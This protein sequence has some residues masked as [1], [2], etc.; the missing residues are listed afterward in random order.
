MANSPKLL[1]TLTVGTTAVPLYTVTDNG[2]GNGFNHH[3][4]GLSV[5]VQS[6]PLNAGKIFVGDN[7]V[8]ITK[9]SRVLAAGDFYTVSGSAVDPSDVWVISD[10]AAQTVHPSWN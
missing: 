10:T 4:F 9:Y 2:A 5:S 8:S 1:P 3:K 6:D 7:T